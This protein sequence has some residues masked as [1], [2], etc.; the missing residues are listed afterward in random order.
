LSKVVRDSEFRKQ[1]YQGL[2]PDNLVLMQENPTNSQIA[3]K[4]QKNEKNT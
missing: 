3:E 2:R 4:Q 1:G